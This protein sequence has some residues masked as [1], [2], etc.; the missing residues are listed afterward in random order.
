MLV[1]FCRTVVL[2]FSQSLDLR[3]KLIVALG[4][5]D[6][7]WQVCKV[8]KASYLSCRWSGWFPASGCGAG[9][10]C[11]LGWNLICCK[12]NSAMSFDNSDK[13]KERTW[14]ADIYFW[15]LS[16]FLKLGT[17]SANNPS[18]YFAWDP[19]IISTRWVE[20]QIELTHCSSKIKEFDALQQR[21]S[22]DR[23]HGST[24]KQISF[25]ICKLSKK[26]CSN[27]WRQ[28]ADLAARFNTVSALSAWDS[29]GTRWCT[30]S[31]TRG[32]FHW[33]LSAR[34][35]LTNHIVCNIEKI[36]KDVQKWLKI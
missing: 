9:K 10:G 30:T 17:D 29:P 21:L 32:S 1:S 27:L 14:N 12:S 3:R 28:R 11:S 24:F 2:L 26:E 4:K 34:H 8:S 25:T 36:W 23:P 19:Y 33:M 6:K 7:F 16:V 22:K 5:K 18:A 20:K 31:G 35:L 15:N 13:L